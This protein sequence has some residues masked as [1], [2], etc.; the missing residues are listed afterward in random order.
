[1]K[2]L[3][4]DLALLII[5]PHIFNRFPEIIFGFSTKIGADRKAPFFFNLSHSVGDERDLVNEN[6]KLFFSSLDL[7]PENVALQRQVHS[8]NIS[9]VSTGGE[10]G[11]SDAM[12]TDK[13]NVGLAIS[14]ADC[15]A[16][17]LYD[18][19]KKI[20]A[21]VHSGWRGTQK[22]ILLKTLQKL[23]EDFN[24]SAE[25]LIAYIGPS[26]SQKN[27]EVGKE[28]AELFEKKYF[29]DWGEK[30]IL[31]VSLAN[32]DMLLNFGL[33]KNNIQVSSLCS[34]EINNILHSYR[35]DGLSSGRAL[36]V[37]AIKN[38]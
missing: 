19:K 9:Y 11:E 15:A 35:R 24:S 4:Y 27:Y 1:M 31:N 21:A 12:I 5:K 18:V 16:I 17:F 13:L 6:R 36:G 26:I 29:I 14:S 25:D 23:K 10:I 2:Y 22:K 7:E 33:S 8:D 30:Y 38:Y 3:E 20:I 28:V 37:I 32:Y 34:Y